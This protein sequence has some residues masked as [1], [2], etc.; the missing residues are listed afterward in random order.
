M[1]VVQL[2]VVEDVELTV[3]EELLSCYT[4]IVRLY[5]LDALELRSDVVR[6]LVPHT[7]MVT[8]GRTGCGVVIRVT[9]SLH[10]LTDIGIT[11]LSYETELTSIVAVAVTALRSHI[12]VVSHELEAHLGVGSHDTTGLRAVGVDI[13]A[14]QVD[15]ATGDVIDTG[16]SVLLVRIDE[17]GEKGKVKSERR[18]EQ[19]KGVPIDLTHP[20]VI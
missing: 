14:L 20:Q 8:N 11:V 15:V 6:I 5:G 19:K 9:E 13:A 17:E 18:K 3:D 4:V 16:D 7:F 2:T 12:V 10:E 1:Y